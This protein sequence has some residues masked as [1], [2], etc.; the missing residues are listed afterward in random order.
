MSWETSMYPTPNMAHFELAVSAL[1]DETYLL[2]TRIV[3]ASANPRGYIVF[4]EAPNDGSPGFIGV[5]FSQDDL[6]AGQELAECGSLDF[7]ALTRDQ[8]RQRIRDVVFSCPILA[9]AD[10]SDWGDD[11]YKSSGAA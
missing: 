6:P 7:G 11:P 3:L 1:A 2:S 5:T 9:F 10:R 4:I 8:M